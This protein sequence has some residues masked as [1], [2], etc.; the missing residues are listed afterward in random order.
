M[1]VKLVQWCL[2]LCDPM[3]CSPPGSSAHGILQVRI[4]QWVAI[5]LQGIFLTQESNM[6]LPHCR[7]ILYH[8]SHQG[9]P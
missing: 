2:T 6:G 8:L 7:Q 4:L 5:L 9:S 1:H 3:D